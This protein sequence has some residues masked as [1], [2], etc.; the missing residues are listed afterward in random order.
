MKHHHW[1]KLILFSCSGILLILSWWVLHQELQHHPPQEIMKSLLTIS[2]SRLLIA[3]GLTMISY[4]VISFYDVIAF[5]YLGSSLAVVKIMLTAFLSYAISNTT[6]FAL[7]IGGGIRYR[8]Y[9]CWQV[10]TKKIAQV[11]G[12]ANLSF[13]LGLFAVS[14]ITFIFE[15]LPVPRLLYFHFLTV[16]PLGVLFLVIVSV[17]LYF[18]WRKKTLNFRNQILSFPSLSISLTQ[19][20][21]SALDWAL[22]TAVLYVLLPSHNSLSYLAFF[23]IYLLAI[24]A[25]IISHVPGGLGIFETVIL[26]LLPESISTPDVLGSLLAYRGVYFLFPFLIAI[27]FIG[28]FEIRKKMNKFFNRH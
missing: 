4:L 5:C 26:Y 8:Y 22:A 19:I 11:L 12:F 16:R 3:V 21:V 9:S 7:L 18:C 6:G 15:P 14:G 25:A 28:A 24:T 1:Y 17:Y 23:G 2:R 10:P 27:T 20:L 13:W